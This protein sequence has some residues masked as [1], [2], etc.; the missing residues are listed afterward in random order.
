[1]SQPSATSYPALWYSSNSP[2][3]V[4]LKSCDMRRYLGYHAG[5]HGTGWRRRATAVPLATGSAGHVGVQLVCEW[6]LEWQTAHPHKIIS[7]QELDPVIAWAATDAADH[8]E[9]AARARGLILTM[10]DVNAAAAN[11][12]LIRE[13]A[14]VI[15]ALIWI[16]ATV[17]LPAALSDHRVFGVELEDALVF[18]CTC[19]LGDSISDLRLHE[20][21]GCAGI[22]Y[23]AKADVLWQHRTTHAIAYEEFKFWGTSNAGKERQWEHNGQLLV[24]MLAVSRR[25]GIDVKE[26]W[27]TILLKGWRG[28]DRSDPPEAPKYQHSP[29]V[30]GYFDPGSPPIREANW[31]ARYKWYD[32]YGKGHTLPRSYNKR[33]I[34]DEQ[35]PL[36][37]HGARAGAS[38]VEL[39][40]KHF[41]QPVQWPDLIKTLGPFPLDQ[42]RLPFAL[43]GIQVEE[44]EWYSKVYGLRDAGAT[45]PDH[46]LINQTISRSWDCTG[47]DGTPCEYRPICDQAPGWQ[48]PGEMGI[49]EMRTPHH[50]PEEQAVRALGVAL[51]E[52]V[53]EA[54][55]DDDGD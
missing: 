11:D 2:H 45:E 25:T 38:R 8:Y 37:V 50:A 47:Y 44:R 15:E 9:Q 3:M 54:G 24:N 52:A 35:W 48:R 5:Q 29:L 4:G 17:R 7:Q 27:A 33:P 10:G 31:S 55:G 26:A 18:D 13:Q 16:W 14:T 1:M 41:I 40:V 12:L 36:T 39:W 51:P 32:E 43:A 34:F 23:Q 19:G 46:A 30:Y 21:R 28:R 6:L 42:T 49:Y 22:A 20:T 53:E